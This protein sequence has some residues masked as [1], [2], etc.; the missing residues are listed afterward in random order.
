VEEGGGGGEATSEGQ[1]GGGTNRELEFGI[2]TLNLDDGVVNLDLNDVLRDVLPLRLDD[3]NGCGVG[4]VAARSGGGG[5]LGGAGPTVHE[6]KVGVFEHRFLAR[7]K[8]SEPR[9]LRPPRG[10]Q[11]GEVERHPVEKKVVRPL[12]GLIQSE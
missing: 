7:F 4:V 9:E 11:H 2:R 1:A 8:P 6:S 3:S 5:V 12:T 10:V